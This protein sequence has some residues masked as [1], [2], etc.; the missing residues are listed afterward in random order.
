MKTSG[1]DLTTSAAL[2][3]LIRVTNLLRKAEREALAQVAPGTDLA[4]LVMAE[5]SL[6]AGRLNGLVLSL[7]PDGVDLGEDQ[8]GD[9]TG[10]DPRELIRQ[11]ELLT[12]QRPVHEFPPG[13]TALVTALSDTIRDRCRA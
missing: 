13:T 5:L 11:A 3:A 6:E 10:E 4:G 7:L 12:R 1:P 9:P 2:D 8:H